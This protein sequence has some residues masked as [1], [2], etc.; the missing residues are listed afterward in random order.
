M[1]YGLLRRRPASARLKQ[2]RWVEAAVR[3]SGPASTI[4][5]RG[6][7]SPGAAQAAGARA[8]LVP[9]AVTRA[10]EVEQ[11]RRTGVPVVADLRAAVDLVLGDPAPASPA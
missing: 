6:W 1:V 11:A 8:V 5:V 10:E 7:A 3:H 2:P 9:T 4:S